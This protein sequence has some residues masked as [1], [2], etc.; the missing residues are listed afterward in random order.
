MLFI[1]TL[2]NNP[3]HLCYVIG[4]ILHRETEKHPEVTLPGE[5]NPVVGGCFNLAA[6]SSLDTAATEVKRVFDESRRD[7]PM[8]QKVE[9][10]QGKGHA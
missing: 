2:R 5:V 9:P 7:S 8:K 3:C 10:Q 6:F 4:I 1:G